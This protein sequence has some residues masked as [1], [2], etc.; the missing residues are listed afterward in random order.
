VSN[1]HPLSVVSPQAE[2][3]ADVQIGPFCVIEAGVR[4]DAGT[5]IDSH[6]IVRED[7]QIGRDNRI[8][9]RAILGGP[10]Q[11]LRAEGPFGALVIGDGNL[12]RENVTMHRA[13][14][15]GKNTVVGNGN[16]F[17]VNAHIAHDCLVGNHCIM[18]NN[19]L[20]SGHVSIDDRAFL[21]GAVAVHQFCRIGRFAMVGGQAHITQD[22][23]PYVTVDGLSSK[24]VGLNT[25]G[26]KR[27][28]FS[29]P[30]IRQLKEAYQVIYRS[31]FTWREVIAELRQQY[32]EGPAAI[33]ADFLSTG[34]RG[35]VQERRTPRGA[36]VKFRVHA[37]DA[38]DSPTARKK[39]AG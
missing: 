33:Y 8:H 37:D 35:Y 22:V 6:V 38:E 9:D 21:S 30:D 31:G 2:L 16:M 39:T 12:I 3:A 14:T 23:P 15:E 28:G 19:T 20:L 34:S 4:I 24:V 13:L 1:I 18:A 17:M 32:T 11:H 26:L 29:R 25:V 10:P 7:T 5:R 27:G 36:T